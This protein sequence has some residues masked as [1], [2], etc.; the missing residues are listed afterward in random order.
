MCIRDRG[1]EAALLGDAARAGD[2]DLYEVKIRRIADLKGAAP[3]LWEK[4][5]V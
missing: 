3:W 5:K 1:G 2:A 4:C